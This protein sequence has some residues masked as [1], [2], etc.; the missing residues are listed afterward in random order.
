MPL[1]S[2][3]Y[4]QLLTLIDIAHSH[5]DRAAMFEA[6][7]KK[8]GELISLS[9]EWAVPTTACLYDYSVGYEGYR[10][11]RSVV[12]EKRGFFDLMCDK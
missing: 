10:R 4:K 8:M 7:C 3:D 5:L 1:S 2:S 9:Q 6:V 12:K 11:Q